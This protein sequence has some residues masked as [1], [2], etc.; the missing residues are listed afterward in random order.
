M[1]N[2]GAL[3]NCGPHVW[4]PDQCFV[5]DPGFRPL[6]ASTKWACIVWPWCLP[7]RSLKHPWVASTS[8]TPSSPSWTAACTPA[9]S[10]C[11]RTRASQTCQNLARSSPVGGKQT[12]K[13]RALQCNRALLI[14]LISPT[15]CSGR[16]PGFC[17]GGQP[18]GG[19]EDRP[20]RRQGPWRD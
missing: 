11:V 5:F 15:S 4:E 20:G 10:S 8:P 19:E 12:H 13:L 17:D 2:I 18:G 3:N 14:S 1:S 7:T 9:T 16:R 6:T